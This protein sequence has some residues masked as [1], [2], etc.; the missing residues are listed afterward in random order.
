MRAEFSNPAALLVAISLLSV[1]A[2]AIY[3]HFHLLH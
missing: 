1:V 2:T 3:G